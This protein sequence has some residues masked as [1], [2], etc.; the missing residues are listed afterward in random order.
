[1]KGELSTIFD[2]YDTDK[3]GKLKFIELRN[4]MNAIFMRKNG[5]KGKFSIGDIHKFISRINKESEDGLSMED[6]YSF[7]KNL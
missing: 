2:T 1:M 5:E 4:M 3:D 6:L 7:Y